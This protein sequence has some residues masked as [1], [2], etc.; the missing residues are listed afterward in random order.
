MRASRQVGE[1]DTGRGNGSAG[2]HDLGAGGGLRVTRS[3][4]HAGLFCGE[5]RPDGASRGWGTRPPG[6]QSNRRKE[7]TAT[8]REQCAQGG[9][10]FG[11]LQ[12]W[13][14][15]NCWRNTGDT[16][17]DLLLSKSV[18]AK[19]KAEHD[20]LAA[21]GGTEQASRPRGLRA[22]RAPLS[23]P[24]GTRPPPAPRAHVPR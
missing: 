11:C 6:T 9:W 21:A 22:L 12:R 10:K 16:L 5:K 1:V 15:G 18:E 8:V 14:N 7:A 20:R 24:A 19:D 17:Q 13:V 3:H 2:S 23:C 4:P